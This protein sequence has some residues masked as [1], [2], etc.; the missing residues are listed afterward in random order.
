MRTDAR[1][2]HSHASGRSSIPGVHTVTLEIV[3]SWL[4]HDVCIVHSQRWSAGAASGD[5]S[6]ESPQPAKESRASM[7][8]VAMH[9]EHARAWSAFPGSNSPIG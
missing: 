5:G 6:G 4:P 7:I 8:V 9:G 1:G 3:D 2:E